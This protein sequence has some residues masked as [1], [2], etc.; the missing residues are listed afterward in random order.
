MLRVE[1]LLRDSVGRAG[2]LVGGFFDE[3]LVDG[4]L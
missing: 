3:C 1:V 2:L 4:C